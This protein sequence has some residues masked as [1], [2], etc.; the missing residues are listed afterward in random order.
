MTTW[1]HSKANVCLQMGKHYVMT[2]TAISPQRVAERE[3]E[4]E[5]GVIGKEIAETVQLTV[6]EN[7]KRV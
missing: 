1:L 2:N 3:G 5:R 4:K 6:R 7:N